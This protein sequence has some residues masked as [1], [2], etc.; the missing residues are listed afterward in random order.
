MVLLTGPGRE[1]LED[2][3]TRLVEEGLAA[4]ANVLPDVTSI[5]RWQGRVERDSEALAMVKT[6]AGLVPELEAR[7]RELH[8]YDLPE[9]LAIESV[10]GNEQYLEWVVNS[11][12][13]RSG[14]GQA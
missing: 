12:A 8:S 1:Q 2:L 5:Y 7:V 13:A 6:A 11:V 14:D 10:G 4:C 9:V 3:A